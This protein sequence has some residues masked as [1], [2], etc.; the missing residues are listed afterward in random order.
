MAHR[1]TVHTIMDSTTPSRQTTRHQWPIDTRMELVEVDLDTHD[2]ELQQ[3]L[4]DA[5]AYTD[6][7]MEDVLREI[8]LLR[9]TTLENTHE[10]RRL[11]QG[12]T[13]L[14]LTEFAGTLA[15]CGSL[16]LVALRAG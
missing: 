3:V 15:L 9:E 13:A 1:C 10:T 4:A 16:V 14:T 11:R 12:M 5:K 6:G 2:A 7:E 8:T